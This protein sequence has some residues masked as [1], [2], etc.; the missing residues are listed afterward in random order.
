MYFFDSLPFSFWWWSEEEAQVEEN[1][2]AYI[3]RTTLLSFS[4]GNDQQRKK[5]EGGA[6]KMFFL[7]LKNSNWLRVFYVVL[8]R[9]SKYAVQK[10]QQWSS[11]SS[12]SAV[13]HHQHSFSVSFTLPLV[14]FHF[15]Y[16]F[17]LLSA[18]LFT[19]TRRII[20]LFFNRTIYT[21]I[22]SYMAM[23]DEDFFLFLFEKKVKW[24][25]NQVESI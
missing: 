23:H 7:P 6:R 3:K 2:K 4:D 24:K 22:P 19:D 1:A 8:R 16:S 13:T 20:V 12:W 15:I 11:R 9:D 25:E 14:V 21:Y 5:L 18:N 10:H 17:F